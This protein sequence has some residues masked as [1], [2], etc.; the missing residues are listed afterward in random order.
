VPNGVRMIGAGCLEE[1]FEVI[2]GLPRLMLEVMLNNGD[3]L[4]IGVASL[5]VIVALIVATSDRDSMGVVASAPSCHLWCSS[6]RP[7]QLS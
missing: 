5:L 4:L 6:L 7:C 3:K 2:N 1:L